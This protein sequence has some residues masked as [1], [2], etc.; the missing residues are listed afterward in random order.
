MEIRLERTY[1]AC[2]LQQRSVTCIDFPEQASHSKRTSTVRINE[3]KSKSLDES[4]FA[5]SFSS[6]DV[7]V[8][9]YPTVIQT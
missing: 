5:F 2:Q 4:G 9:V 7:R 1:G 6:V 3:N 8:H